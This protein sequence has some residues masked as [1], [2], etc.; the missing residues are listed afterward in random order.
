VSGKLK[1]W[2]D[3]LILTSKRKK[4]EKDTYITDL[5]NKIS[6]RLMAKT[7]VKQLRNGGVIEIRFSSS[8]DLDRL[9]DIIMSGDDR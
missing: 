9:V 1:G 3:P 7:G 2:Q 5:E 6:E 4:V 8:D